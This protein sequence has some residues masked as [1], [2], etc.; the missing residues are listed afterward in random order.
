MHHSITEEES[1]PWGAAEAPQ[2]DLAAIIKN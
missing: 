1:D 2:T